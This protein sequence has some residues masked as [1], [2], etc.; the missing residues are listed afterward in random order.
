MLLPLPSQEVLLDLQELSP[1][2]ETSFASMNS[3]ASLPGMAVL[4]FPGSLQCCY[5]SAFS[6]WLGQD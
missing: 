2:L 1:A 4:L 6:S 3:I 5:V